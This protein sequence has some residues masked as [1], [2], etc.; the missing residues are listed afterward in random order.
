MICRTYVVN[1]EQDFRNL[2]S[3]LGLAFKNCWNRYVWINKTNY[4]RLVI[5][6][7]HEYGLFTQSQLPIVE[8]HQDVNSS[9]WAD[10]KPYADKGYK[11][12]R[13]NGVE[14]GTKVDG[15]WTS[16]RKAEFRKTDAWKNFKEN[17][18]YWNTCSNG[19][20]M[21]EDCKRYYTKENIDVHHIFPEKYDELER[22]KFMLLCHD[23]HE[24]RTQNGE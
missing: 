20:I 6:D 12:M 11:E 1:D 7:N 8:S 5:F 13:P 17:I 18:Y 24:I 16:L 23:C 22:D 15:S 10:Y 9:N 21:C 19:M 4:Y 14:S 3:K 2:L